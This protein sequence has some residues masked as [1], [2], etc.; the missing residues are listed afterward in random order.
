M[1]GVGES[2]S[3]HRAAGQSVQAAPRS[4]VRRTGPPDELLS[5]LFASGHSLREIA[6]LAGVSHETVRSRL[7][8]VSSVAT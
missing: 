6:R 4:R 2:F 7:R 8:N 5:R 1:F 3:V